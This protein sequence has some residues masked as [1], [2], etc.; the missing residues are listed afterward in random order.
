M[1]PKWLI[2]TGIIVLLS[3]AT[4]VMKAYWYFTSPNTSSRNAATQTQTPTEVE[5][6]EK[7]FTLTQTNW[8]GMFC[9][10][11]D[12]Q[13]VGDILTEN[14]KWQVRLD[15]NDRFI[16]NCPVLKLSGVQTNLVLPEARMCE[17]RITPGEQVANAPLHGRI[18]PRNT[19]H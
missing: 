4:I 1:K 16:F 12:K 2:V 19:I 18:A 8:Q 7:M 14:V 17:W 10:N 6:T 5:S 13:I 9:D 3:I 15:G 11:K